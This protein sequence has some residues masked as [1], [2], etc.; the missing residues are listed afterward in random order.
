[1]IRDHNGAHFAITLS[2][3]EFEKARDVLPGLLKL[4]GGNDLDVE[5][6]DYDLQKSSFFKDLDCNII[7]LTTWRS[8]DA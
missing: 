1:M 8:N 3:A 4:G 7:E 5:Y 6:H 2:A